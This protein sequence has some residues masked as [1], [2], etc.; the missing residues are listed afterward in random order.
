MLSVVWVAGVLRRRTLRIAGAFIG[1]ALAVA[2]LVAV[3]RFILSSAATM[4][5]RAASGV[6]VD[7]QVALQQGADAAAAEGALRNVAR[8]TAIEPV[9]YARINGFSAT[10]GSSTQTTSAG[11]ALGIS[12]T[13]P[14]TFPLGVR[15]LAGSFDGPLLLQQTAANLH[16]G[17][18]DRVTIVPARGQPRSVIVRG[19]VDLPAADSLF[20]PINPQH[21]ALQAPPDNVILLPMPA[22]ES[23]AARDGN[24]QLH[25]RLAH[26]L[27][28]DPAAAYQEVRTR[29]NVVEARLAGAVMIGDN[30]AARLLGVIADAAY[31][32][33]L[34]L[35]LGLPGAILMA[36][37]TIAV[38]SSGEARRRVEQSLLRI[39]GA[40]TSAIV[41]LAAIEAWVV[42][43]AGAV[44]G[45]MLGWIIAPARPGDGWTGSSSVI[46]A[47]AA[48]CGL[49]LAAYAIVV[50]AWRQA[51]DDTPAAAGR[52]VQRVPATPL[53]QVFYLDVLLLVVAGIAFWRA[54][55][56][57]YEIVVAPEGVPQAT[58]SYGAFIAPLCLWLGS[59]LLL[60]R[61]LDIGLA[62]PTRALRR[63][64]QPL[65][66]E[67]AASVAAFLSRQRELV[68]RGAVLAALGFG[69]AVSTAVFNL[70]YNAQARVDAQLTN[71]ADVTVTGT[72]ADPADRLLDTFAHVRGVVTAVPMQHRYAYVGNDLQDLYGIDPRRI[73][74]AT[75]M[76]NAY[77]ESGDARATLDALAKRPDGVL[78]SRETVNDFR[79]NPGDRLNLRLQS[80]R[81]HRYRTVPFTLIGVVR[82]F[83]TAPRDSFLVANA[84]Y[85]AGATGVPGAEIVLIRTGGDPQAV[86]TQVQ[87][88]ATQLKGAHV[89][90]VS[91]AQRLIS[92][93]LTAVDL[94]GLTAL[95]LL[96]AVLGIAGATG[97]VLAL[98][99]GERRRSFVVLWALGAR[100]RQLASY[101]WNE[102]L[103]VVG[104]GA[105]AGSLI[106]FALAAVLVKLLTGV[107]DPPPQMLSVPLG[108]LLVFAFSALASTVAAVVAAQLSMRKPSPADLREL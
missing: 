60:Y 85:V 100:P 71:G 10:T 83:P 82:E 65:G 8:A 91:A 87:R 81:D 21:A 97:I 80:A 75:A 73:A 31:A 6:A 101:W 79:L 28:G 51:R 105:L 70:T 5:S 69:F 57:G 96:F 26:D 90:D 2:L 52:L 40:S 78:V 19:V 34:F 49:S 56:S 4:S 61:L 59:A 35:F 98:G 106:G 84:A 50:P 43:V 32:R 17:V 62:R 12:P 58:I 53:W 7:W 22:W 47:V 46:A 23:V 33:L 93:S 44:A 102:A 88:L 64:V 36:L 86:A 25:V 68:E 107:F 74:A 89:S 67:M 99:F 27:P 42:G 20:A 39:R 45:I 16:V 92:S 108:S 72:P 9:G 41:M 30:L 37:L 104:S 76:S 15:L 14:A 24:R 55:A 1:V 77:F 48:V 103:L 18:G 29:A 95:E 54:A 63:L 11:Y 13:Y 3:G 66:H 38:A 94:R